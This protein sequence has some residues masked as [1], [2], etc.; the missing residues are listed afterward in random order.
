[1]SADLRTLME[2]LADDRVAEVPAR[3]LADVALEAARRRRRVRHTALV[4][5]GV[6]V[7]L[8]FGVTLAGTLATRQPVLPAG[9]PDAGL[10]REL[11]NLRGWQLQDL[12]PGEVSRAAVVL[13][14]V[15]SPTSLLTATTGEAVVVDA[16]SGRYRRLPVVPSGGWDGQAASADVSPDGRSVAVTVP[17]DDV[18]HV[19]D[20][21]PAAVR[22]LAVPGGVSRYDRPVWAPGGGQVVVSGSGAASL[23]EVPSGEGTLLDGVASATWTPDGRLVEVLDRGDGA[24]D[25]RVAGRLVTTVAAVRR[26]TQ[27]TG[28]PL[29]P[30]AG[31][32]SVSPGGSTLV[33]TRRGGDASADS[34]QAVVVDL[35]GVRSPVVHELGEALGEDVATLGWRDDRAVV[36]ARRPG[37]D[38][39]SVLVSLDPVSGDQGTVMTDSGGYLSVLSVD[40]GLLADAAWSRAPLPV[41]AAGWHPRFVAENPA[42]LGLGVVGLLMGLWVAVAPLR[43]RDR[44]RPSDTPPGLDR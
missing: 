27:V 21:E 35:A 30:V 37:T 31:P 6:A 33:L 26:S 15:I 42:L 43:R 20:L 36:A 10:P 8:A 2:Q 11:V 22:S 25:V 12:E 32:G 14:G 19:V 23:V 29:A 4:A 7:A 1:M 13:N 40:R 18:L 34:W 39:G 9:H 41:R 17:G 24:A 38:P 44:L 5:A 3:G 16:E 28:V